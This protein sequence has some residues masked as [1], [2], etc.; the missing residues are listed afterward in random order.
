MSIRSASQVRMMESAG[1]VVVVGTR[2]KG[3]LG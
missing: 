2:R 3:G 1:D